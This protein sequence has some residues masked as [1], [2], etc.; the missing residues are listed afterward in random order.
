MT[1]PKTFKYNVGDVVTLLKIDGHCGSSKGSVRGSGLARC[2][3]K[4][5]VVISI[6]EWAHLYPYEVEFT[7]PY[8]NKKKGTYKKSYRLT[9]TEIEPLFTK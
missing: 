8:A 4:M 6:Y 7:V 5:G 3:G 2:I 1:K 9:K